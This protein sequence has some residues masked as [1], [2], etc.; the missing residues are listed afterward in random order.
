MMPPRL[1]SSRLVPA[2]ALFALL[3]FARVDH[4][5]CNA[6]SLGLPRFAGRFG[7]LVGG[8]GTGGSWSFFRP[9]RTG[10]GGG[11][12]ATSGGQSGQGGLGSQGGGGMSGQPGSA[13]GGGMGGGEMG[14][15]GMGGGGMGGGSMG[16]GSMGGGGMGGGG[17]GGGSMGGGSMGG[18]SM[19]GGSMGGGGMGGGGMGGGGMGGGGMGGGGMGGGGMGGGGMGGGGMGGGGMGGGGMG[20]GGMG[21]GSMGGGGMGGG[22]MGGGG[23]GGGGMGGGGMGGGG[24][25]GGGMGGG[26]MGG[27]SMG[28]GGMGGG[29]MG[30]GSMGGGGMGGGSMGGGGMGGGGIGGGS[31]SL[32][33]SACGNSS[34]S[35]SAKLTSSNGKRVMASN[36]CPGYDWRVQATLYSPLQQALSFAVPLAP[37][38]SSTSI[39]VALRG[40]CKMGPIGFALNGV[41][42]YSMKMRLSVFTCCCASHLTPSFPIP[43][44]HSHAFIPLLHPHLI[45]SFPIPV[46]HS[47]ARS[48]CDALGRD[49]LQ[50]EGATFDADAL[51]YEGATFDTCGGHPTPS[52]QYHYHVAPGLANPSAISASCTTD[53]QLCRTS[54]AST[55]PSSAS[56]LPSLSL[57]SS[58]PLPS[59]SLPP[60]FPLPPPSLPPPSPPPFPRSSSFWQDAPGQ[61]SPLVGFLADGIPL[62]GPRGAGG[63]L[64]SGLDECG[65]HVGDGSGSEPAFY[66]YHVGSTAPYTV[67]CLKGCVSSSDWGTLGSA[68]CSKAS[69][70]YD[71]SPL[72]AVQAA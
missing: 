17:I 36:G 21:G 52:G 16:G 30:G 72:A 27:G 18:G 55:P 32:G 11:N 44:S 40:T 9:A 4:A 50:Y 59:P 1:A 46:S 5:A 56:P 8:A 6:R 24:M 13:G 49:A 33:G 61:H 14:G 22:G 68:F 35:R 69:K 51:Q 60:H 63:A 26:G 12:G 38:L 15:G 10:G 58:F 64:P 23:M 71:Y 45:P 29:G 57:L 34:S 70:Q 53:F 19:G 47:P 28:G 62:Y 41:P 43:V 7:G 54:P 31:G 20:G 3:C 39:P 65:G 66:H 42:F 37:T 48:A 2:L 67:A 25:G